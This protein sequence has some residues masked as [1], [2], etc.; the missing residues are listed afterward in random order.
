MRRHTQ[1]GRP[2]RFSRLLVPALVAAVAG[3]SAAIYQRS[4]PPVA[5]FVALVPAPRGSLDAPPKLDPTAEM[6]PSDATAARTIAVNEHAAE[7][8]VLCGLRTK[9]WLQR[10]RVGMYDR[11]SASFMFLIFSR[12]TDE[13]DFVFGETVAADDLAATD[14]AA[15]RRSGAG[16][17][18]NLR[19]NG[20]LVVLDALAVVAP[21]P[22][23]H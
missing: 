22:Q 14:Y 15:S 11:T 10:V 23:P 17:C 16:V 4:A 8:A 3:A 6:L 21:H 7:L 9:A 1:R 2:V 5:R 20:S 13:E 12:V 18:E 19:E